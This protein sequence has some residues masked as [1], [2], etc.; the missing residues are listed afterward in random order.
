[1]I[2]DTLFESTE[3]TF[4]STGNWD[5]KPVLHSSLLVSFGADVSSYRVLTL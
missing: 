5:W 4:V 2:I 1:M 3:N